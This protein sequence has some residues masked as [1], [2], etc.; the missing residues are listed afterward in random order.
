MTTN[1]IVIIPKKFKIAVICCVILVTGIV[2]VT[3]THRDIFFKPTIYTKI[4]SIHFDQRETLNEEPYSFS[5]HFII[6]FSIWNLDII[7]KWV[8]LPDKVVEIKFQLNINIINIDYITDDTGRFNQLEIKPG[9][10]NYSLEGNLI[11]D[12]ITLDPYPPKGEYTFTITGCPLSYNIEFTCLGFEL[13]SL[14]TIVRVTNDEI[15]TSSPT[16]PERWGQTRPVITYP[17]LEIISG[18]LIIAILYKRWIIRTT[19]ELYPQIN[20]EPST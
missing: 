3:P 5:N 17:F 8:S 18:C 4:D 14:S 1:A 19:G 6:N 2:I 11:Y 9:I 15:S 10:S 7:K 12:Q 20:N 16:I 13:E